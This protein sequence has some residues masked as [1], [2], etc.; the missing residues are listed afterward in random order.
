M[1]ACAAR[2]FAGRFVNLPGLVVEVRL[3]LVAAAAVACQAVG[4]LQQVGPRLALVG[5]TLACLP[6]PAEDLLAQVV[7][8][9][10]TPHHGQQETA[11]GLAVVADPV[12]KTSLVSMVGV[13]SHHYKNSCRNLLPNLPVGLFAVVHGVL[14]L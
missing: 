8:H 3:R 7:G 14:S 9:V 10:F 13:N 12:G 2:P 5:I 11:H 1:A 4:N 6:R